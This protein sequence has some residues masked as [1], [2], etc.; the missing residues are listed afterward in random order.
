MSTLTV[1]GPWTDEMSPVMTPTLTVVKISAISDIIHF[2]RV[3][4]YNYR[5]IGEIEWNCHQNWHFNN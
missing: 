3:M 1:T 2:G 4:C 5:D